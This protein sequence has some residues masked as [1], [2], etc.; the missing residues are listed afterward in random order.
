MTGRQVG[1]LPRAGVGGPQGSAR[2]G[3]SV[4]QIESIRHQQRD[5]CPI[6]LRPLGPV[7]AVD[8]DHALAVLHGHDAR[9]G[10]P[11]CVRSLLCNPCNLMLGN[12]QDDPA[13]LRAGA[14]YLDLWRER[15]RA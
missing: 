8:H 9:R 14:T 10:C 3:L 2:H 13:R 6:C 12:A 1:S 11:R 5:R 7:P 15:H 4:K